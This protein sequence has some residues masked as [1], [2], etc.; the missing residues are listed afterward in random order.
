MAYKL[1]YK[2]KCEYCDETIETTAYS[3]FGANAEFQRQGWETLGNDL[4]NSQHYCPFHTKHSRHE[5]E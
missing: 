2:A 5:K 3:A 4:E 1:N